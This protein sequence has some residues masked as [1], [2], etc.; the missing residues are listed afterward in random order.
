TVD[1]EGKP[2]C[3]SGAPSINMNCTSIRT[4]DTWI[5]H[6]STH[7]NTMT[8]TSTITSKVTIVSTKKC[9]PT[10]CTTD[11]THPTQSSEEE[12]VVKLSEGIRIHGW[13]T[14]LGREGVQMLKKRDQE[15][16]GGMG[17]EHFLALIL[18]GN[19]KE[20]NCK[21]KLE[22]YCKSLKDAGLESKQV[23]EKLDVCENGNVKGNKCKELEKKIEDKC[24]E[25]EKELKDVLNEK[26]IKNENCEKHEPK[27]LFL[28]ACSDGVTEKCSELRN[29]CYLM[30]RM[31][32]AVEVLVRALS[33]SLKEG[34]NKKAEEECKEKLEEHC[35]ILGRM[36]QELMEKCLN[37]G[38]ACK[39][40]ITEAE[41]KCTSLKEKVKNELNDIKNDSCLLL[42]EQCYFYGPNCKKE[43]QPECEEL[44]TKCEE[45]DIIYTPPE[46]PWIPI[47]PMPDITDKV[48]LE[49]LYNEAAKS[50]LLIKGLH[51]SMEN[52]MLYLSQKSGDGNFDKGECEKQK[53]NCEYLKKLSK[54]SSYDCAKDKCNQLQGKLQPKRDNLKERIQA[55]NLFDGEGGDKDAKTIPWHKLNS[56]IYGRNCAE[57]Q[58]NCFFLSRYNNKLKTACDN[59]Q[60]MCYKRGLHL[61]AY[62]V[63]EDQMRREL[64]DS[65]LQSHQC[66][67]K[68][69]TICQTL[70]NQSYHLLALCLYPKETC[71]ILRSDIQMKVDELDDILDFARDYPEKHHC[72]ELE[73]KCNVLK[74]DNS[75]LS[76]PCRTLEKNCRHLKELGEIESILLDEKKDHF[77]TI[78][79]CTAEL[80]QQCNHW[81]RKVYKPFSL[82]CALQ[83]DSC[84]RMSFN[85]Y[86][87]CH[88]L[89]WNI[90][91][92]DIVKKL[93]EANSNMDQ[94]RENCPIWAPYCDQLLPN[95]EDELDKDDPN[96]SLCK[97]IQTYCQP[98]QER[99]TLEDAVLYEFR[100]SL[101]GT[102]TCNT[103]LEERCFTWT[104][105]GNNT[106]SSLCRKNST[107]D[108]KKDNDTVK[109]EL[110]QRL[111]DRVKKLCKKLPDKLKKEQ[112]ELAKRIGVYNELKN[113]TENA[114]K[115]TN[116]ILT[117]T[118]EN[119]TT[120]ETNSTPS[121]ALVK[122]SQSHPPI[123]EKE[124]QAFDLVAMTI[125]LYVDLK[126]KCR[127][128]LLD[129][130]FKECKGSEDPCKGI[131]ESCDKL[132]PLEMRPPEVT[133]ST[134]TIIKNVTVDSEGKTICTAGTP[135]ISMNCTSIHT[136]D[137]WV[138][139]TSTHTSTKTQTSTFTS[140]VTIISTKKCQPTQCTTDRT[141]P[142]HGSGGEEAGDVK[143][144]GGMRIHGWGAK[145]CRVDID[146]GREGVQ[147]LKKRDQGEK[148]EVIGEEHFLALILKDKTK[149]DQC[150]TELEKYCKSL[151]DAGLTSKQVDDKLEDYCKKGGKANKEKCKELEKNIKE[152][153][154]PFKDK[155]NKLKDDNYTEENCK[156]YEQKCHFLEGACVDELK[157]ECSKLRNQCYGLKRD[158]VA[159]EVLLRALKGSL[160]E[161]KEKE[162]E[163]KLKKHCQIL[164]RMSKE[165]MELCLNSK[166]TCESLKKAAKEKCDSLEKEVEKEVKDDKKDRCLPLLEECYFYG[167]NC[168]EK[169]RQECEK[170][171]KECE[172]EHDIVYTPPE[173]PW[174]P[175]QPRV[176]IIE[177][178]GLKELYQ[179]IAEEGILINKLKLPSMD[180]LIILLSQKSSDGKFDDTK[181]KKIH[182]DKCDY[183]KE[184]LGDSSYNCTNID[185][186][187][188]RLKTEFQHSN[189]KERIKAIK[190][191][192]G[193][194]GP[195]KV[196]I[197]S[198]HELYP[199]FNG[200]KCA[201]LQSDCFFLNQY[202]NELKTECDNIQ[203]MCYKRGLDLVAYEV[204]E[205]QMRGEF[206]DS[207]PH[208]IFENGSKKCQEKLVEVC[209]G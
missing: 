178:V 36:S 15:G 117:F 154:E 62:E 63:L 137:T 65:R 148:G 192:N 78:D 81:S 111:V 156:K 103:T 181:C 76:E 140:K 60:A 193:K 32:V 7:T 132:K 34:K 16:M 70:K 173:Q 169:D 35:P 196:E 80:K 43:N 143:P 164:N 187:C 147:M 190:R 109:K 64:Q 37:P 120:N 163:E 25:L 131:K 13:E 141:Y 19:T 165:L 130:G 72:L 12:E 74:K 201:Q 167:P 175:I 195:G 133:T 85:I 5:T 23:H 107:Y 31:N 209:K 177:E 14:N 49:E 182:K 104:E 97:E 204:L 207:G 91:E 119:N 61:A 152:K 8:K 75:R 125:D 20:N 139:H 93:K 113:K 168:E 9:Q 33:G 174:I 47:Q 115:G 106:F 180:D 51:P 122:R 142:T 82:S 170:L 10:Q 54:D 86:R 50:G 89:K 22:K 124:A 191:F 26:P 206:R 205:D 95:C 200:R 83:K 45:H 172:D 134:T 179:A 116:V 161:K 126:E 138:T 57:L 11:R 27:C 92:S 39:S 71:R 98:Y 129:C 203:A 110:C 185:K 102:N 197:I 1:S 2:I 189:L 112:E 6:T 17:E 58:S 136:T 84:E 157:E 79:N 118:I 105:T 55:S 40:L 114:T 199:D 198:W 21:D 88:N 150:K 123:T 94:L 166:E 128:L 153:C 96:I 28:G 121:H 87:Y 29:R 146:L 171:K 127:K 144:S 208:W 135:S 24:T 3:T 46:E 160:K 159:E 38:E 66:E 101:N 4:T 52:L 151:E 108:S 30:K 186:E 90:K 18:K 73:P 100:G 44:K 202:N 68:L 77:Q 59:V 162:C 42:L 184:L 69:V 56:D 194:G 149:D 53:D 48:G 145:G 99:Q 41:N 67:E 188:E 158:K 176:S 155:L 183:L